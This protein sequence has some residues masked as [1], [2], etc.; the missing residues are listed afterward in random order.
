MIEA[1]LHRLDALLSTN[2]LVR[3]VEIVRR[4]I[5]DTEFE[6]VLHYRYRVLLANG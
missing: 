5:R 3:D 6:K 4:S 1:Y 2:A